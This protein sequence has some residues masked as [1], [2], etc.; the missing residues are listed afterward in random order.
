MR[1]VVFLPR[2]DV[3]SEFWR[4]RMESGRKTCMM[5]YMRKGIPGQCFRYYGGIYV[6]LWI[7]ERTIES[8]ARY[9][10]RQEGCDSPEEFK[11]AWQRLHPL[12][13]WLPKKVVTVH[14]FMSLEEWK[15]KYAKST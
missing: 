5:C 14:H 7:Q 9:L 2:P 12:T 10:F 4:V 13:P 8:V 3:D 1:P 15:K 11:E 6:I